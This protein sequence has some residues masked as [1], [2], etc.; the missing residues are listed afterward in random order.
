MLF[1]QST[2]CIEKHEIQKQGKVNHKA[3]AK[4]NSG[5]W[6][7]ARQGIVSSQCTAH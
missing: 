1:S 6:G 3:K 2:K 5:I 7:I 4:S